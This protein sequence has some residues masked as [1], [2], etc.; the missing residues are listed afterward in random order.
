MFSSDLNKRWN[1]DIQH[2]P[3]SG[4]AVNN[5]Y[6]LYGPRNVLSGIVEMISI[7]MKISPGQNQTRTGD[8]TGLDPK[9][10]TVTQSNDKIRM[11]SL[12]PR[13]SSPHHPSSSGI[14][15]QDNFRQAG[16]GEARPGLM[17]NNDNK[18]KSPP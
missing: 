17:V 8:W 13:P 11:I 10:N 2:Q 15:S 16:P 3:E 4:P 5:E 7:F 18:V 9:V 6:F 12:P 1:D 14:F